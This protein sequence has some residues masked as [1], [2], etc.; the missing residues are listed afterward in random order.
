MPENPP[1]D[2]NGDT[3]KGLVLAIS[4]YVLWGFLPIYMKALVHIGPFEV[5]AHRII[6]SVPVAGL[7]LVARGRT[8][9]LK[10]VLRNPRM[11]GMAS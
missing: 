10:A 5:V 8:G 1:S 3:P 6:W 2:R 7:L 11:L 4:A 9:D